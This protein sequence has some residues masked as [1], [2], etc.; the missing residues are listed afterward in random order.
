MLIIY[1]LLLFALAV[2]LFSLMPSLWMREIYEH[3][4]GSRAV[5]CPENGQAVAVSFNAFR[6]AVT[7]FSHKP[8]L[9]LSECTRWPEHADCGQQCIPQARRTAAYYGGEVEPSRTKPIYHLPVLIASL[10]AWVV[11]A[12][13]HSQFVFRQQWMQD[14]GL[15]HS[16]LW[17]IVWW[18]APHFLT[19]AAC[20]LF[21]YGVA[22]ILA[23]RR[24][25]G[26]LPGVIAALALWGAVAGT[27][28]GV[29]GWSHISVNLLKME[30]AYTFLASFLIGAIIGGLNGRLR[31]RCFE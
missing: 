5:T 25:K 21:S 28:L 14:V 29:T 10:L 12:I 7:G 27:S 18:R 2:V 15:N 13:W 31:E 16:Q 6:A 1:L 23:L 17:Q 8:E 9:Q 20:I 22:S 19:F 4:R 24:H 26:V 11:G 3:Y 30:A